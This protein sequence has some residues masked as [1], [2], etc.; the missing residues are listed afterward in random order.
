M[1][2]SA[3]ANTETCYDKHTGYTYREG[4]QYAMTASYY[5]E[6]FHGRPTASGKTF[7]MHDATMAAHKVLPLGTEFVAT[8]PQTGE[9]VKG[10]VY[11]DG[12]HPKGRDLDASLAMARKLGYVN[13][14]VT[15]LHVRILKMGDD[16]CRDDGK[17]L[18]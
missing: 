8:N 7:N 10:V 15:D 12:P 1:P 9:S 14:G 13:A 11:D 17:G 18:R 3:N 6:P 4:G 2:T 5:E 16:E